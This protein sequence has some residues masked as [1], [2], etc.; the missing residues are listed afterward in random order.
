MV[1]KKFL[2]LKRIVFFQIL[3]FDIF[4]VKLCV[5]LKFHLPLHAFLATLWMHFFFSHGSLHSLTPLTHLTLSSRGLSEEGI[6]INAFIL[7]IFLQYL[8]SS[9]NIA[10][11]FFFCLIYENKRVHLNPHWTS[12]Y[13][14]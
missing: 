11:H 7:L 1:S 3:S 6:F 8:H 12:Q 13:S 4:P 9:F 10:V 5:F 2:S 14:G